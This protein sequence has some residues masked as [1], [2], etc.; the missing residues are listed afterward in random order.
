M[1]SLDSLKALANE[2]RLKLVKDLS[3]GKALTVT[4]AAEMLRITIA[5]ASRHLQILE[6]AGILT[7]IKRGQSV[8]YRMKVAGIDAWV[9]ALIKEL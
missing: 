4:D 7:S 2:N 5:A 3:K 8:A 9:K 6:E 1:S